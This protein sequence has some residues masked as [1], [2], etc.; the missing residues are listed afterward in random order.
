[1]CAS[2]ITNTLANTQKIMKAKEGQ[3]EVTDMW[4]TQWPPL[5]MGSYARSLLGS[6]E[7]VDS[8]EPHIC[9]NPL[10]IWVSLC[11]CPNEVLVTTVTLTYNFGC[12]CGNKT[13]MDFLLLQNFKSNAAGNLGVSKRSPKILCSTEQDKFKKGIKIVTCSP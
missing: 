1:M 8:T 4:R 9:Y 12:R 3:W 7:S 5:S 13:S 6:T 10:N 11:L 2:L